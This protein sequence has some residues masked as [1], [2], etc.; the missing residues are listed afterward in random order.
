MT[1]RPG[2][3]ARWAAFGLSLGCAQ[4][5]AADGDGAYGRLAGDLAPGIELGGL[6]RG[7]GVAPVGQARLLY[8]ASVGLV[9]SAWGAS[10]GAPGASVGV[11]LRPLFLPRFAAHREWGSAP[12][13]LLLD[14]LALGLAARFERGRRPG[15]EASVGLE[16]PLQADFRG[17]YLGLRGGYVLTHERASGQPGQGEWS[18]MLTLGFRGVVA[19]HLADAGDRAPR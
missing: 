17:F 5:H 3:L 2:G 1:R 19:V 18:G 8:V 14:S 12:A 15:I 10:G 16:A 11:E 4:A 9:G 7:G 13:D 6:A